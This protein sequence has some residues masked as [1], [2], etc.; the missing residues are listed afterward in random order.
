MEIQPYNWNDA[1]GGASLNSPPTLRDSSNYFNALEGKIE[2][3]IKALLANNVLI[4]QD[5]KKIYAQL[6]QRK[7]NFIKSVEQ[8]DLAKNN[9]YGLQAE[10][11]KLDHCFRAVFQIVL[12]H[13]EIYNPKKKLG[14][15]FGV[16][17][18]S[19]NN[20]TQRFQ[21]QDQTTTEEIPLLAEPLMSFDDVSYLVNYIRETHYDFKKIKSKSG[22]TNLM[23]AAKKNRLSLVIAL[24]ALDPDSVKKVNPKNKYTALHYAALGGNLEVV[25]KLVEAK[26]PLEAR[27]EHGRNA[28][29][30]AASKGHVE[31]A[32]WLTNEMDPSGRDKYGSTALTIC[33]L[34]SK[35]VEMANFLYKK[36][37]IS[38]RKQREKLSLEIEMNSDFLLTV[39]EGNAVMVEWIL[40]QDRTFLQEVYIPDTHSKYE[41]AF[42]LAIK[43]KHF[44]V[45]ECLLRYGAGVGAHLPLDINDLSNQSILTQNQLFIRSTMV[46]DKNNYYKPIQITREIPG[47]EKAI[48]TLAHL[49][50]YMEKNNVEDNM[51]LCERIFKIG[52]SISPQINIPEFLAIKKAATN[53]LFLHSGNGLTRFCLNFINSDR[54]LK[55]EALKNDSL[56]EELREE[57][58]GISWFHQMLN[59]IGM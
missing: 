53:Y 44:E 38:L 32:E 2:E 58:D 9:S 25:K 26:V 33:L 39:N 57:I 40:Q 54:K 59:T 49:Q 16:I 31:V 18:A 34:Y 37:K 4:I 15:V 29:M 50:E 6:I 5:F 30:L 41:T 27:N 3:L 43:R 55:K 51:E 20:S 8:V 23:H 56:P 46:L 17:Q 14:P 24:L 47:F 35:N 1:S 19:I 11:S 12:L 28:L 21:C 36:C 42:S 45:A 7:N 22:Q 52:E 10:I 48:I 13:I